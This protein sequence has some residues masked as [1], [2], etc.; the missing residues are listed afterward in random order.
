MI[1]R[2]AWM[3]WG[4][5]VLSMLA[6]CTTG[7]VVLRHP[8]TRHVTDCRFY[9]STIETGSPDAQIER[10]VKAYEQAGYKIVGDSR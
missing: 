2:V 10:C 8:E 1:E 7:V 6:G 4:G 3:L 9:L 5:L